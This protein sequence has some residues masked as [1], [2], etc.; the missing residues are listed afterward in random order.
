[1]NKLTSF[2]SKNLGCVCFYVA[3]FLLCGW[4]KA[5]L[6]QESKIDLNALIQETQMASEIYNEVTLVWWVPEEFWRVSLVSDPSVTE[7]QIE[8]LLEVVRP[9]TFII[10]VDGRTGAFGKVT[11]RSEAEIRTSIRI[12]DSKGNRYRPFSKDKVDVS[13]KNLLSMMKP[14][15]V[16]LLGPLGQN[17]HFFLFPAKN[18]KDQSICKAKKEGVFWVELG[19]REFKWR[20][21]LGSLFPPKI[22]PKCKEK[23]SGAWQFCPWCGTELP[24]SGR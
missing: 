19:E 6:S 7:A 9:Y 11:Y 20:L 5:V 16:S 22:C 3:M 23:C 1:M 18:K 21:P 12:R 2:R 10:V 8:E 17:M 14:V 15:L 13:T 4:S 24:K